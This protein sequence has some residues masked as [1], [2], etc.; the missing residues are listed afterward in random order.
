MFWSASHWTC[1][2]VH[3]ER[4]SSRRRLWFMKIKQT[5]VR[6]HCYKSGS[7]EELEWLVEGQM[8]CLWRSWGISARI[9]SWYGGFLPLPSLLAGKQRSGFLEALRQEYNLQCVIDESGTNH[10][11]P[12]NIRVLRDMLPGSWCLVLIATCVEQ[13]QYCV[14]QYYLRWDMISLQE[15]WCCSWALSSCS[16]KEEEGYTATTWCMLWWAVR[17]EKKNTST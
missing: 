15:I 8:Q 11:N 4:M 17:R 16:G 5:S 2:A 7:W 14:S 9:V 1:P 12:Q 3:Y 13:S 6:Q 10:R